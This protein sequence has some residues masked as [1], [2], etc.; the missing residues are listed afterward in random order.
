MKKFTPIKILILAIILLIPLT[1]KA[2]ALSNFWKGDNQKPCYQWRGLM[3]DESRH[4]FGKEKVKQLLDIMAELRLNVFHWHLTDEPGWRIEIKAYPKL[5]TIGGKGNWHDPNAPAAFYTQEDIKEIVKYASNKGIM[6][7]PEIDMP[8]HATAACRAYP[9][10]SGGGEGRWVGF[11]F[12]PAKEITYK[13]IDD[14]FSEVAQLFPS[15]YIHI[16]GDE[17]TFGNQAWRTDKTIVNF[18]KKQGLAGDLE[19]EHYFI[20]KVAGIAKKHNKK[21]IGWDEILNAGVSPKDALI[22]W[23]RHDKPSQ[24][25]KALEDGYQVV[26]CPR[27]PLYADFI[28]WPTDKIGRQWNGYNTWMDILEFPALIENY[29][30]GH[31]QQVLGMQFNLWTERVSTARRLDYMLFPR[32]AAMAKAAWQPDSRKS[33]SLFLKQL[34]VFLKYLDSL[35]VYY[36]DPFAPER[37]PEPTAPD[38]EDVLKNG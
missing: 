35:G 7:I 16:G 31:E 14:V 1:G 30:K 8:G 13:F 33:T 25:V 34:P 38:K 19:L 3:L 12:N 26:L 32:L 17:V 15:P 22:M 6:I 20:R 36:F 28:Q 9:E 21:I 37:H 29:I 24:L 4:F 5:T 27:R 23:W 2:Q 11:T 18:T 10:L